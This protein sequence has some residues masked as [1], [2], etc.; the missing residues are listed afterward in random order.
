LAAAGRASL[1]IP[2]PGATDQHQLANARAL[3]GV[4]AA[5][6]I[7]QAELTP[8]RLMREIR[9]LLS[10][11]QRLIGME[12]AAKSLARPGAAAHIADLVEEMVVH[13]C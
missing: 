10:D 13:L 8:E 5:R 11:P 2:F 3:E 1:L 7:L 12:Q 4:G 6:V 9:E